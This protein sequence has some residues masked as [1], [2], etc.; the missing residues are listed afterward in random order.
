MLSLNKM[1]FLKLYS[2]T[3]S[4]SN[5]FRNG[6]SEHPARTASQGSN[7]AG[8]TARM[9]ESPTGLSPK[10]DRRTAV[11][12]EREVKIKNGEIPTCVSLQFLHFRMLLHSVI[13]RGRRSSK[14]RC[15]CLVVP[16]N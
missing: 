2:S 3:S 7:K 14:P 13:S 10:V 4:N 1:H 9:A 16:S 5:S 11:S 15:F 6:S 8:R 12:A